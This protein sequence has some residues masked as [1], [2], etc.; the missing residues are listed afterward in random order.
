MPDDFYDDDDSVKDPNF[1][2]TDETCSVSSSST[3]SCENNSKHKIR[4]KGNQEA[5]NPREGDGN[6]EAENPRE[7]DGNQEVENPREGD[8]NQEAENPREEEACQTPMKRYSRRG[9]RERKVCRQTGKSYTTASGKLVPARKQSPLMPCRLKCSERFNDEDLLKIFIEYWDL[10]SVDS[11][12]NYLATLITPKNPSRTRQRDEGGENIRV[13]DVTYEH[14]LEIR[15]KRHPICQRCFLR[16][17]GETKKFLELL[18]KKKKETASGVIRG[19]RRGTTPNPRRTKEEELSK[20]D[21]HIK[22]FPAY[23]SH[24]SRA[25][26]TKKYLPSTLTLAKMYS[27]FKERYPESSVTRST[28]EKRFH[29]H[30]LSFKKP[31]I[32]TC[33]TCDV[34]KMQLDITSAPEEKERL[35]AQKDSHQ[36]RTENAYRCKGDDTKLACENSLFATYTFDLQQCLPT[37]YLQSSVAFYKRLL[38]T[39]NLTVHNNVDKKVDCYMWHET[40]A[41]RGANQIAS[42]LMKTLQN[43]SS[44]VQHVIFYSDACAGQNRNSHMAAMFMHA[45]SKF[46]NILTIDHKFLISGHSRMECDSDHSVIERLK[47]EIA[48]AIHH[49]RDWYQLVR[50]AGTRFQVHTMTQEDFYDYAQLFKGPLV[51][52]SKNSNNDQ[53]HWS[54]CQWF[55]YQRP[56][57][58][59]LYK[60][61]LSNEEEFQQVD[62]KRRGQDNPDLTHVNKE[63]HSLLPISKEKKK[64]LIDLLPLVDPLF[65]DFYKA[66]PDVNNVQDC[67]PDLEEF[68][69]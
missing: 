24:Y 3:I 21:D 32:D 56:I 33:H 57:G 40:I 66:L 25:H 62:M 50:S 6:Q 51:K 14:A 48:T 61:S 15:M 37:P 12:R 49:P 17:F 64:D 52:R 67:D 28:Y 16:V 58:I 69:E 59:L 60:G 7:R 43:L 41:A 26:S 68:V 30:N 34:L 11:R 47:K 65:H 35:Q 18:Q 8:G 5:E 46:P 45:L 39:Y 2:A 22:S 63:Y 31:K 44:D 53:F 36:E 23:E 1:E 42:C 13:R 9:R 20:I 29:C 19:D 4:L 27:L 55:S 38:W 10:G 54:Q